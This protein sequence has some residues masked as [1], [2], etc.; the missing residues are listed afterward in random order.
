MT[1]SPRPT[2]A[3]CGWGGGGEGFPRRRFLAG[4]AALT[5]LPF[6][7]A[8][9]AEATPTPG[10]LRVHLRLTA[11]ERSFFERAILPDFA[12]T[13]G[14]RVVWEDGTVE[15]AT[16]RLGDPQ[17]T[18][19]LIGIDTERLG[20]LIAGQLLQP[21]EGQRAAL[22][23]APWRGMLPALE[24]GGKLYGLPYRPTT[25]IEFANRALLDEAGIAP[26]PTWA[27][28]LVAASR[29]R[30]SNGA[31]LVALQGAIGEPAART[32]VELIWAFDGDPLAPAGAGSLAAGEFL[33]RLGPLLSPVSRDASF[34]SMT[35]ALGAGEVAIGPNWPVVA[36][37]L[38]QRGG[39]PQIV[40]YAG[41]AGP[42]GGS[43]LLSG[44]VLAVPRHATNPAGG[45]AFATYLR[46]TAT[47]AT[48]ARELAWIP[49]SEQALDAVPDWQR[50]VATVAQAALRTARTLPPLAA[51]EVFDGVM[52]EAFRAIAFDG[53][54][55]AVALQKAKEGLQGVAP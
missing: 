12:R 23:A 16:A 6:L 19:D 38:V 54:A 7:S 4:A 42:N 53:E 13:H 8:C 41:P 17:T 11:Y 26:P 34:A 33:A 48:L 55:P 30:A 46:D 5:L 3:Q 45:I 10:T 36:A 32:L 1:T 15:E 31:G 51:R 37:D 14:L 35:K 27:D 2:R 40:A 49:P 9:S 21:V 52:G 29:L 39:Q 25:W 43:R 28:L 47:Q 50:Q 22:D 18:T 44:Q 20:A 24:S